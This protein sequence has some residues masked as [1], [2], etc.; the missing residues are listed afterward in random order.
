MGDRTIR[1]R[2]RLIAAL[3]VLLALL[4][5]SGALAWGFFGHETTARIALANVRPE[6]R[7]A[8]ARLVAHDRELG[9]P[10]C[11]IHDL[12]TAATWP[13]CIRREAW[14]WGY[15]A[16][17][18]FQTAPI[19][20]PFDAGKR[21][22]GGNCVS[23]Q[24]SRNLRVLADETMPANVRL[25][26]LAFTVH[27]TGDI[28]MPLHSGDNDD[29]GGNAV[30]TTYGIVPGLNLHSVWDSA[31]AERAITSARP[32]LIRRYTD[33]ER[34]VLAGGGPADWG[35]ESWRIAG[36]F[37]YPNAFGRGPSPDA[38]LPAE[39]TLTQ[40]AIAAAIP[41]AERR[42]AQ[43]GLRIADLLDRAFA[44]G[45]LPDPAP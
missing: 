40:E 44:P 8:I 6:T 16:A 2:A 30:D 10:H 11:R 23:A 42:I 22:G 21:C 39:T 29:R 43:A 36:S 33:A 12:P 20:E 1:P 5:P 24:I 31:L 37:V 25:E 7:A 38:P 34:A 27:F 35:R 14:R 9:T 13:D 26:A 3:A 4:Q 15:T 17:W 18:H 28:H 45:P 32:P 41:V 19:T